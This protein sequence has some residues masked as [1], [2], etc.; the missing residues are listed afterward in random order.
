[1]MTTTTTATTT[2]TDKAEQLGLTREQAI[3]RIRKGLQR[4]TGKAWSVV[5]GRG[6]AWGWL[7]ISAPPRRRGEFDRM[8]EADKAELAQALG[9]SMAQVHGGVS[10]PASSAYWMEYV[11]R[12]EGRE[13]RVKGEPY[14]D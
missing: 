9:V 13:P 12:A 8:S 14:W 1:M 4:R 3:A 6:T 7:T 11:D 10:V 2:T 5:G